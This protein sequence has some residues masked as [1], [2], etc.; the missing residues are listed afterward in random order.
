MGQ[1]GSLQMVLRAMTV[2]ICAQDLFHMRGGESI[3]YV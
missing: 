2:M 1:R 3:N